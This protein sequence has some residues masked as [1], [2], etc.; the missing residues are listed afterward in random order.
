MNGFNSLE[1]VSMFVKY[2]SNKELKVLISFHFK[3]NESISFKEVENKN[4]YRIYLFQATLF[5]YLS[6]L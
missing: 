6:S 1:V 5:K 2:I 3:K 4:L